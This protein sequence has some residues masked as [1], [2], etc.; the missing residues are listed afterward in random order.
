MRPR[1]LFR[2]GVS[3]THCL[4]ILAHGGGGLHL[5]AS[6]SAMCRHWC[7]SHTFLCVTCWPL[8]CLA[9]HLLL[10]MLFV[11]L[12]FAYHTQENGEMFPTN[13]ATLHVNNAHT[14]GIHLYTH[15]FWMLTHSGKMGY[16]LLFA[17][18]GNLRDAAQRGVAVLPVGMLNCVN[19][20]HDLDQTRAFNSIWRENDAIVRIRLQ[21]KTRCLCPGICAGGSHSH[22]KQKV[23]KMCKISQAPEVSLDKRAEYRMTGW[24]VRRSSMCG[25][26]MRRSSMHRYRL[27]GWSMRRWSGSCSWGHARKEGTRSWRKASVKTVLPPSDSASLSRQSLPTSTACT[28]QLQLSDWS[29]S[30][31]V[32][33]HEVSSA[34]LLRWY[35]AKSRWFDVRRQEHTEI[36]THWLEGWELSKNTKNKFHFSMWK[37]A[38]QPYAQDAYNSRNAQDAFNMSNIEKE[39]A[40]S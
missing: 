18:F 26:N 24:S 29:F 17:T 36:N 32:Q 3:I 9:I 30:F 2:Q 23:S 16:H 25:S 35:A 39:E 22:L 1:V 38:G 14:H 31:R 21:R 28:I 13:V 34:F 19:H 8:K 10:C 5:S 20:M 40:Y 27:T 37:A 33:K 7:L 11:L 6:L 15:S 4:H 12:L